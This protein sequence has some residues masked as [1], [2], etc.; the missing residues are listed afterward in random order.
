MIERRAF[1]LLE[2]LI[3]IMIISIS[4]M[5]VFSSMQ[6]AST[7]PKSLTP[8][9]LRLSLLDS[10]ITGE[11]EFLCINNSQQCFIYQYNEMIPYKYKVSL[12]DIKVYKV[13]SEENAYQVDYGRFKDKKISLRFDI[14]ANGSSTQMIIE[15]NKKFFYIPTF[16]GKTQVVS[17]LDEAKDLWIKPTEIIK[18]DGDFY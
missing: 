10:N 1:S 4:Y 12:Q 18:N 11:R 8:L 17:S 2:L 6:K 16:F 5:L 3:V 9:N 15:Q 7:E 14:Y 13:N